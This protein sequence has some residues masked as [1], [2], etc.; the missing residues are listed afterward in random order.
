MQIGDIYIAKETILNVFGWP[1][2]SRGEE[3]RII[4][5]ENDGLTLNHILYANEYQPISY[6]LFGEKFISKKEL[7]D[8][9]INEILNGI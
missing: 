1:L 7:R 8:E 4:S 9:K 2:Y 6:K 3:Y 5:I